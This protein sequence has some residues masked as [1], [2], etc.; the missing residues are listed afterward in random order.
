MKVVG[1]WK[2]VTRN[3]DELHQNLHVLGI[4]SENYRYTTKKKTMKSIN[5]VLT[6]SSLVLL[7]SD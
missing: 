1:G 4:S 3:V 7:H 2:E 6:V 5:S